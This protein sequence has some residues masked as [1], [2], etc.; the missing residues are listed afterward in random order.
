MLMLFH[1][2]SA[3][4]IYAYIGLLQLTDAGGA[5]FSPVQKYLQIFFIVSNKP[6]QIVSG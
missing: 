4:D 6:L 2:Q 1:S 5:A 3:C